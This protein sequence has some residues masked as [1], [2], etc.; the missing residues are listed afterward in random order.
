MAEITAD[1]I[2]IPSEV[3]NGG[4]FRAAPLE[5][6][7][8]QQLIAPHVQDAELRWTLPLLGRAMYQDMIS[9]KSPNSSNYNPDNGQPLQDK[10]PNDTNYE[11][12]W[13]QFLLSF[14]GKAVF[15]QALPYLTFKTG[16]NG[17]F[18]ND[19]TYG[20]GQ[21]IDE[22]KK[23]KDALTQTLIMLQGRIKEF[24]CDN[25]DDYPLYDDCN[26]KCKN[27]NSYDCDCN[28]GKNIYSTPNFGVI[29]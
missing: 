24:L 6:R 2:I 3:I 5:A 17:A 4:T 13:T 29:F 20:T 9:K 26:C 14:S 11:T 1:T 15:L 28:S 25:I 12:L 7:F 21:P 23:I 10:F 16:S 18:I 27:C 22:T 19:T 8:D